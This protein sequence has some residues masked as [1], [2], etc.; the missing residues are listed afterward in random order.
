MRFSICTF[1]F[2]F[3]LCLFASKTW[4]LVF[5]F[6]QGL[7]FLFH[8]PPPTQLLQK[9]HASI[10][11]SRRGT[12][13]RRREPEHIGLDK[14]EMMS[15]IYLQPCGVFFQSTINVHK[16]HQRKF[17]RKKKPLRWARIKQAPSGVMMARSGAGAHTHQRK[18]EEGI[19]N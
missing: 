18:E 1:P 5:F 6:F 7:I 3:F 17:K 8:R 11:W 15:Q 9:K 14:Q 10:S 16:F 4:F 12:G 19:K 13:W 2:F